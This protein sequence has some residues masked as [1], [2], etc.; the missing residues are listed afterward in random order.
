MFSEEQYWPRHSVFKWKSKNTSLNN[1]KMEPLKTFQLL[2][3][4]C[5]YS[6]R[7]VDDPTHDYLPIRLKSF[8]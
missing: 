1:L 7:Y 4:P 3:R 5:E 8:F 2:L 6:F